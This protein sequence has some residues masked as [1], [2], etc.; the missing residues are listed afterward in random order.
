LKEKARASS[1]RDRILLLER[2]V[3]GFAVLFSS[4]STRDFADDNSDASEEVEG[5][6]VDEETEEAWGGETKVELIV[7]R[8]SCWRREVEL[9]EEEEVEE[10]VEEEELEDEEVRVRSGGTKPED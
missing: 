6:S 7:E 8:S 2:G 3:E 9:E 4:C 10:E 5:A 1:R